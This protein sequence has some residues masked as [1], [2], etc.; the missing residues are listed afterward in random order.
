VDEQREREYKERLREWEYK[1][2]FRKCIADYEYYMAT[3]GSW[4]SKKTI[5]ERLAAWRNHAGRESVSR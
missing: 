1:E 5:E 3:V 2:R 4:E